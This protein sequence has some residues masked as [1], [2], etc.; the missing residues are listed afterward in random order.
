MQKH[1]LA[2]VFVLSL[3][4]T[5]FAFAGDKETYP[6]ANKAYESG[7][8]TKARQ[9]WEKAAA[10]GD[11]TAMFYLGLFYEAGKGVTQDYVKARKWYGRA[12]ALERV[13]YLSLCCKLSA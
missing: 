1:Y 10:S 11:A 12:A 8:Y 7:N 4:N 6:E 3:I 9:I 2:L 5:P 13:H